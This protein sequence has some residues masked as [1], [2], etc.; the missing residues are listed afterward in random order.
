MNRF[1]ASGLRLLSAFAVLAQK[2][3]SNQEINSSTIV[4]VC[5]HGSARSVIAAAHFNRLASEKGLSYRAVSRGKNPD[6]TIPASIKDALATDG[7]DVSAWKP[8]AVTDEDMR[9]A[10]RVVTLGIELPAAKP[11]AQDRLLEWSDVPAMSQSY[12]AVRKVIVQHVNE[13]VQKLAASKPQ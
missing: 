9:K 10:G 1:F 4:F 3:E 12:D 11:A 7:L 6:D 5:E 13:L 8:K 2:T